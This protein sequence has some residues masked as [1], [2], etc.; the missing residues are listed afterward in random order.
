MAKSKKSAEPS[1]LKKISTATVYGKIKN[2]DKVEEKSLYR[3][4]GLAVGTKTGT[5]DYGDWSC[6]VGEFQ[7]VN[8]HTGEMFSSSKCFLPE[9]VEAGI[10]TQLSQVEKG[11]VKFAFEIGIKPNE[12]IVIGYEYTAKSLLQVAPNNFLAEMAEEVLAIA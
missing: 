12:E 11:G 10:M 8:I 2:S 9:I 6:F 4:F 7:A 5:T 3:V 1:L